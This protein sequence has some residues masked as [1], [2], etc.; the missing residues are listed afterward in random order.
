MTLDSI[1]K[2]NYAKEYKKQEDNKNEYAYFGIFN[3]QNYSITPQLVVQ[4]N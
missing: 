4:G 3:K 1:A 2:W